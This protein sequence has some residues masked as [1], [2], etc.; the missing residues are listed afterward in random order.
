M[1][2]VIISKT[3]QILSSPDAKR[4]YWQLQMLPTGVAAGNTGK[5]FIG[6]GLIP[7]A[8]VGDPNQGEILISGA[9]TG[10]TKAYDTDPSVWKGII[11]A[12]ADTDN[13]ECTFDEDD[14]G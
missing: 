3:P 10:Q 2:T 8:V 5:V 12:V 11:W 4:S 9:E 1:R 7:N 6:L 14:E 13:Q